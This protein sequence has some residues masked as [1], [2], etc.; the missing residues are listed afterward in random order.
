MYRAM[1]SPLIA[2]QVEDFEELFRRGQL[3]YSSRNLYARIAQIKLD[4]FERLVT[5]LREAQRAQVL[6][7]GDAETFGL[8]LAALV[9]GL[10][11]E[12]IDEGL[13]IRESRMQPWSGVRKE[14]SRTVIE[15]LLTG[16][17]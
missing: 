6:K 1:F 8:A 15:L 2:E 14:M 16:L 11:G 5:P 12:F 3:T 9:Y 13:G 7:S 4:A 17:E 10:V